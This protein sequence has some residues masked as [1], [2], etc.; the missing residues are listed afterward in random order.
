M[1]FGVSAN[2]SLAS[3]G[4]SPGFRFTLYA[5]LAVTLMFLDQRGQWLS[6]VRYVLQGAA[7][8][9]QLA[10][11]SPSAAWRWIQESAQT[12]DSLRAENEALRTR[13]RELEMQAMRYHALA[14]EN[15]ELRGLRTALPPVAEKWMVAEVMNVEPNSLR[16]SILLNVGKWNGVFKSQAVMDDYGLLGQTTHVGP[17]SCEVILITDPEHAVPVQVERSGVRTIAVGTGTGLALPYLPGN[18]DIKVGDLLLTSGLGGV[19]P[20][21]YPVA[22]VVSVSREAVQPLAQVRAAPLARIDRAREVML[23]WF[24]P[25]HPASPG[26]TTGADLKQGDARVQPRTVPPRPAPV[27]AT[28][29]PASS[30]ASADASK[31]GD[32]S[33][34][35]GS[36]PATR[37]G[38]GTANAGSPS[39]PAPNSST[40]PRTNTPSTPPVSPADDASRSTPSNPAPANAESTPSAQEV[41]R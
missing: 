2:R 24:R 16:Q 33:A 9:I 25:T 30:A 28:S 21:G 8:P 3:R 26:T 19:F 31:A 36:L 17:W 14:R 27:P 7:Y 34:T 41:E 40:A 23:V 6:E 15:A 4:P 18:A 20:Q 32:K 13:Q 5:I 12:R 22:R 35:Q 38:G 10:V 1:A 29:T 39:A 37:A 11:S